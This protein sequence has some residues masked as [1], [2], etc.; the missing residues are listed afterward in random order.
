[1]VF[2]I[3]QSASVFSHLDHAE[4]E[5]SAATAKLLRNL[6]QRH[7]FPP[8]GRSGRADMYDIETICALRLVQKASIFGLDRW[9]IE[10]LTRFLNSAPRTAPNR[11]KTTI[12]EALERA[13]RGE[14]FGLSLV[15][16]ASGR[17]LPEANWKTETPEHD[18]R[19]DA[20]FNNAGISLGQEDCRFTLDAS[21]LITDV[22]IG[23]A[24]IGN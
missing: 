4:R 3:A 8:V 9:Q 12:S 23:L 6:T 19:V 18:N 14:V 20:I 17:F 1:M 11:T 24:E 22:C 5:D 10:K 16:Y 15:M 2:T 7:Y 13:K 21:R